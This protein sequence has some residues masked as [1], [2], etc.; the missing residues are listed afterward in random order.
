MKVAVK[1]LKV[2]IPLVLAVIL[3]Y[4]VLTKVSLSELKDVLINADYRWV[5]FS[6]LISSSTYL[7]RAYRWS[8]LLN[9]LGFYPKLYPTTLSVII[10]Y[11]ANLAIPRLGE[12]VRCSVL[13]KT[14]KV[15]LGI[16]IG[17][18]ISDRI[19]D[20]IMLL[21]L[22]ILGLVLEF[23][24]LSKLIM[25]GLD[26]ISSGFIIS[27]SIGGI[28]IIF[29]IVTG[30]YFIFNKGFLPNA[31]AFIEKV[32]LGI[33]SLI[34]IKR[35]GAFIISTFLLWIVYFL[36]VYSIF[37]SVEGTSHLGPTTGILLVVTGG[38]ALL[39][40]VQSGFGTYH[41]IV[42][43]TLGLYGVDNVTGASLAIILHTSQVLAICIFGGMAIPMVMFYKSKR[44]PKRV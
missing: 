11:L 27:L 5:F 21:L 10:G 43:F 37:F 35:I 6:V 44:I 31:K 16:A 22:T 8:I 9:P 26:G 13:E 30:V 3:M 19:S 34:K 36:M 33:L 2:T 17:T 12:I 41:Y 15:T 4:T 39:A 23:D 24:L 14:Q 42:G 32:I 38:I 29:L 28:I 25:H 1:I 7:I 20:L 18:V 40:P